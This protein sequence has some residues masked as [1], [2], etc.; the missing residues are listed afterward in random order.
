MKKK[1]RQRSQGHTATSLWVGLK[2]TKETKNK[3]ERTNEP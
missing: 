1:K 2:L 3:N